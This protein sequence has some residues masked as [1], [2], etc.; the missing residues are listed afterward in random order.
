M[1]QLLPIIYLMHD[2]LFLGNHFLML[3]LL[4][5]AILIAFVQ[6]GSIQI[7]PCE[8]GPY[9]GLVP[10]IYRFYAYTVGSDGA[11]YGVQYVFGPI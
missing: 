2:R 7:M 6:L 11:L 9:A 4:E 1:H 8:V 3:L 5:I 10:T